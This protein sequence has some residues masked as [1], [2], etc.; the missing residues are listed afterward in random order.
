MMSLSTIIAVNEEIAAR[1]LQAK[2]TPFVPDGPDDVD[3]WPP[4]PFPNLGYYEPEGWEQVESWFVDKTG[5]GYESE[6]AMTHRALKETLRHYI[7]DNLGHGFA[8]T[9]EGE[10]QLVISAFAPVEK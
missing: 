2:R 4:F 8:I 6:P 1:A 3:R 9:E 5:V 10:F 7:A